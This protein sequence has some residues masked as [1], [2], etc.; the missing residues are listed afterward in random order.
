MLVAINV[1][2]WVHIKNVRPAARSSAEPALDSDP[3]DGG[4][5]PIDFTLTQLRPVAQTQK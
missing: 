3:R 4:S 2:K 5:I 1:T